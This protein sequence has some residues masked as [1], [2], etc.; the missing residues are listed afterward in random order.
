LQVLVNKD[1]SP[2]TAALA[3][4]AG[5]LATAAAGFALIY[6]VLVE[7]RHYRAVEGLAS[8]NRL[9]HNAEVNVLGDKGNA[10]IGVA[11]FGMWFVFLVALIALV[12]AD[13]AAYVGR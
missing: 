9:L 6:L 1:T 2:T 12:A 5:V 11:G 4:A 3:A 7:R 8:N 13:I 10:L